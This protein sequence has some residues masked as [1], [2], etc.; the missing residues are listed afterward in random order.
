MKT[1]ILGLYRITALIIT[2]PIWACLIMGEVENAL[3]SDSISWRF[4]SKILLLK[5]K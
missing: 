3:E 1:I 2:T 4:L 5:Q